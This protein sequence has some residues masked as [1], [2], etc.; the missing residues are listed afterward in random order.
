M[1][2]RDHH[3]DHGDPHHHHHHHEEE[4]PAELSFD[5]KLVKLLEHWIR[6]NRDHAETYSE[7][8]EKAAAE[9]RGEVAVLL[10]EAVS[11]TLE[12]NRCFEKAV[13]KLPGA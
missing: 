13:K 4:Q 6:H 5:E 1:S 2:P 12:L 3:H 11:R 9:S 7:W 8:A 10:N